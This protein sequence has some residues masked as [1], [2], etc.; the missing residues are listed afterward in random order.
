MATRSVIVSQELSVGCSGRPTVGA[1]TDTVS[2]YQGR[3]YVISG[4]HEMSPG[5]HSIPENVPA[6]D[7]AAE[8]DWLDL[9]ACI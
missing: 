5:E 8:A 9:V 3:P 6:H 7:S 2:K 1:D 4:G